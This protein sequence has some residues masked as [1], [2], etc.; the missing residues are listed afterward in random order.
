MN[1]T[2]TTG[3]QVLS[4]A[5]FQRHKQFQTAESSCNEAKPC[6]GLSFY[7]KTLAELGNVTVAHSIFW[8]NTNKTLCVGA[9]HP[10]AWN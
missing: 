8:D 2:T 7:T 4:L 6:Q 5:P 9:V 10:G 1:T 3:A